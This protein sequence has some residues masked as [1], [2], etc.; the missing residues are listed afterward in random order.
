ML[1]PRWTTRIL[2]ITALCAALAWPGVGSAAMKDPKLDKAED[3]DIEEAAAPIKSDGSAMMER[4]IF[5]ERYTDDL[6][7][8]IRRRVIRVLV[9]MSRTDFFLVDAEPRGFEFD[10]IQKY[11]KY[12]K[13]RVRARSWPV[14]FVF[15]PTPFDDLL[16]A[17]EEGRGDIAAAGLTI[18]PERE[19]KVAFTYPYVSGV[20]EVVVHGRKARSLKSIEDLSGQQVHVKAGTS[21]VEHLARLNEELE[22]KGKEPIKVVELSATLSTED[23]LEMVNAGVIDLTVADDRIANVWQKIL[24]KITVREDLIINEG[25]K[26]AWA[27]RKDN[28][29]LQKS[30][31]V[32]TKKHRK[33]SLIGNIFTKRYYEGTDWIDNP[34]TDDQIEKLDDLIVLFKK[35]GSEYDFDW[36][37]LGALAFQ[38]SRLDHEV[39]SQAGAVGLMQVL[40]GTAIAPPISIPDVH[41]VENNIHAGVKYL[42]FLRD[43]Y[44]ND[45]DISPAAKVDFTLAAYNAGPNRINRL[46]RAAKR[47]GLDSNVWFG[48]VE[49]IARRSI[50]RET[51]DYVANINKYYIA[52]TLVLRMEDEREE[53]ISAVK[54]KDTN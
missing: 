7:D 36:L 47:R 1:I 52:Y 29:D 37:M 28:P 22:K 34:L 24:P 19:K 16:P 21:Y 8:L 20:N 25:G 5:E 32:V 27:V 6:D 38:E 45:P 44:F 26:I 18:T 35:Y 53:A 12:L 30:L 46:R 48:N 43:N 4:R 49:Q 3:I 42:A 13:T 10:M 15:V 50:G 31:S 14:V 2:R 23:L 9:E 51:V 33:G 11:R 54:A 40:P 17:L 41:I 39:E